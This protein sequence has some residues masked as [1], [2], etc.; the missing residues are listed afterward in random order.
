[1]A[2]KLK[3]MTETRR[4]E[5]TKKQRQKERK[6]LR[7]PDLRK[8]LGPKAPPLLDLRQASIQWTQMSPENSED[9]DNTNHVMTTPVFF[10]VCQVD[11]ITDVQSI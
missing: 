11:N 8:F 1:M 3:T 6:A 5:A 2:Q 10:A 7:S 9:D 4:I